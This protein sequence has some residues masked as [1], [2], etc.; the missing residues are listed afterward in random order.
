MDY[1]GRP[2]KASSSFVSIYPFALPLTAKQGFEVAKQF[3]FQC[4][5]HKNHTRFTNS[6]TDKQG[7]NQ[8]EQTVASL[9]TRPRDLRCTPQRRATE[10]SGL[11]ICHDLMFDDLLYRAR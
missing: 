3:L 6:S 7:F 1:V 4:Y 10:A 9:A 2:S 11:Q 5:T 8:S